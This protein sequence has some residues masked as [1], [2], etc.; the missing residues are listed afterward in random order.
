MD[1]E[2]HPGS[3]R[4]QGI[5][6]NAFTLR[7]AIGPFAVEGHVVS[8]GKDLL[9]ALCG[10]E[11]HIGA[12]GM[13]D[14]RPSM[15]HPGRLSSTSSV[16]TYPGHKEDVVVKEISEFLSKEMDRRVLVIA[17]LHWEDLN[18]DEIAAIIEACRALARE[19]VKRKGDI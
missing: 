8:M 9:V 17:G 1:S 6:V 15:R 7:Q 11:G 14:V 4:I 18:D 3:A 10:G 19:I 16:F 5:N 13:A 2:A 12:A